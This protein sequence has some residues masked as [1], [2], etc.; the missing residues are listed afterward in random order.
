MHKIN[1]VKCLDKLIKET[2]C[3]IPILNFLHQNKIITLK[4][5]SDVNNSSDKAINLWGLFQAIKDKEEIQMIDYEWVILPQ[6]R[7]KLT[8]LTNQYMEKWTYG[9]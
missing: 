7:I 4:Q 6:E 1:E 5:Y 3:I 2:G 8:I 9:D